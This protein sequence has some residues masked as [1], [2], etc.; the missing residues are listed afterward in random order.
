MPCN[1]L[2]SV[3]IYQTDGFIIFSLFPH[4]HALV[5]SPLVL[6]LVLIHL[7]LEFISINSCSIRWAHACWML[8]R[9]G[10][11]NISTLTLVMRWMLGCRHDGVFQFHA[12]AIH[13]VG[14]HINTF[15]SVECW[16]TF[17]NLITV[18]DYKIFENMKPPLRESFTMVF[19]FV[20]FGVSVRISHMCWKVRCDGSGD[21]GDDSVSV[22][23]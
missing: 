3:F 7:L 21:G 18:Y 23:R 16:A 22:R 12:I 10:M 19:A 2:P 15:S 1:S 20:I 4:T 9:C 14:T 17:H 13:I 8:V 5:L 6:G 11:N